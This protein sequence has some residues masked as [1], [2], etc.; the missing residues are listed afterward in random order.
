MSP[1]DHEVWLENFGIMEAWEAAVGDEV[2]EM[3]QVTV[4]GH[5]I[6]WAD[7]VKKDAME[8]LM[9][10]FGV[11]AVLAPLDLG[12]GCMVSGGVFWC[13]MNG[14]RCECWCRVL[15]V[16]CRQATGTPDR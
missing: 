15:C 4:G 2:D 10:V 8:H 12:E 3:V 11:L 7:M 14:A 9:L 16:F 6:Y 13:K 5:L 1:D